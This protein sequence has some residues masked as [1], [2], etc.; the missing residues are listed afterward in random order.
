MAVSLGFGI[1]FATAIIL[2]GVPVTMLILGDVLE[3]YG[4]RDRE[5]EEDVGDGAM[6]APTAAG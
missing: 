6:T 3:F 4:F 5:E 1:L 2:I